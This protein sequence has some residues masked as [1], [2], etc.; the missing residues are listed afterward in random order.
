MSVKRLGIALE[1]VRHVGTSAISLAPAV[2]GCSLPDVLFCSHGT[3]GEPST[4]FA[5]F[6]VGGCS[7]CTGGQHCTL[8]RS[9]AR[10]A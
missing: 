10:S 4:A 2:S 1:A 9:A 5:A 7:L 8:S 3:P 6:S